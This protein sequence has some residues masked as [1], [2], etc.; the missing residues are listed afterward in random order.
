MKIAK[1]KFSDESEKREY[2]HECDGVFEAQLDSA[3][4]KISEIESL[5]VITLSG[6]TCSGKTTTAA[7]LVSE[8]TAKG[9]KVHVISIDDFYYN[10]DF[11]V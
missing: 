4:E 5:R 6:P 11:L 8:P 7:K 3:V 2:V 9:K 10:R 1:Y